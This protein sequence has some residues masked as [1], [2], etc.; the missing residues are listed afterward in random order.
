M[1]WNVSGGYKKSSANFSLRSIVS[2]YV[3]DCYRIMPF[4]LLAMRISVAD[5]CCGWFWG[6]EPLAMWY[7]MLYSIYSWRLPKA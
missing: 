6:I 5:A 1:W 4:A 3:C 2:L 7:K